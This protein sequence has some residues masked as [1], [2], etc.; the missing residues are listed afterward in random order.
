MYFEGSLTKEDGTS[1]DK[2]RVFNN[3]FSFSF[4]EIQFEIN[5]MLIDRVRSIGL[6]LTLKGHLSYNASESLKLQNAGWYPK[7]TIIPD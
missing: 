4:R 7:E 1:I 6:T 3:A 5:G 2:L